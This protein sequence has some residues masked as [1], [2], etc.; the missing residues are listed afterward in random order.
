[1]NMHRN[2]PRL[3]LSLILAALWLPATGCASPPPDPPA[4]VIAEPPAGVHYRYYP[5]RSVA[6]PAL[7][8]PSPVRPWLAPELSISPHRP[9]EGT[10]VGV[11]IS[12]PENGRVPL[13]VK[14]ELAGLPVHVTRTGNGWFGMGAVPIGVTGSQLL[15]ARFEIQ[16]DSVV[17]HLLPVTVDGRTF[18]AT[19]LTVAGRFTNP[20]AEVL[21][22]IGRERALIRGVLDQASPEWLAIDGFEWPRPPSFTS[23]FGQR[24]VFN[25]ELQSRHW[26]LDLQGQ[27]GMLVRAAATGRVSL[28]EGF[29]YQGNAVYLDHGL[30]VYTGYFHLSQID[31]EAGDLVRV[32]QVLGRVGATGRVTGPHLHWTL[33][34]GGVSLDA[35]SLM[36]LENLPEAG[37]G[38]SEAPPGLADSPPDSSESGDRNADGHIARTGL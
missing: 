23:P 21:E 27:E 11:R 1:M 36:E 30:G 13:S 6:W 7:A 8:T 29:Y 37:P 2:P 31:V 14:V 26:G 20:P 34:V 22:R 19:Q 33:H 28:A 16:P 15:I 38:L 32:G 12:L 17:E 4:L 18:P 9:R 5:A 25:G 10:A 35:A 3:V 24:R